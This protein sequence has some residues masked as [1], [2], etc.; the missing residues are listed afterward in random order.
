MS[1]TWAYPWNAPRAAIA[2]P[3]PTHAEL[4]R[5][6]LRII[7]TLKAHHA[8]ALQPESVRVPVNRTLDS[9]EKA[10]GA[11]RAEAWL[12]H[13]VARALPRLN[14]VTQRYQLSEIEPRVSRAVFKGHFDTHAQQALA[15]HL[16]SLFHRYNRLPDL[17]NKAIDRLAGDIANFIRGELAD[18]D[19]ADETELKTLHRW[20]LRAGTIALQFNVTPPHWQRV[21][22]KV[23]RAE[24]IAPAVMR[25][26]SE[27]WWR[28]RLRRV[29]SQWREHLQIALGNVSKKKQPYA[30][31][32]CISA[33]REQRRRNREFLKGMELED[34]EGNRI[35]LIDKFDGSVANPAIRRCE[36]MTRI[37]GFETICQ[38]L[39]YVGEFYTLT[40][41]AA[42]HAT[43]RAGYR[44]HKW[45]GASPAQT[46]A[47][48]T[49]LWAR[50]RARLHR[51]GLRIFG[52]RV[53]EP[54]HDGTP[55][56]HMLLFMQPADVAAVREILRELACQQ[57]NQELA[58]EKAKKARFHAEA[59]DPEKGSATGYVAK[60]IAKNIDGYA[61]EGESDNE[62]GAPLQETACAV[63]AWAA[64]W[65]IRQFQFIGGA[66]VTVYRELRRLR[67]GETARGL[68]VEFA[69]VHDAA[70]AGDW[71]G[72][73]NAQG[74]PFVRRDDLQV[75]TLYEPESGFNQYGE[76]MLTIRGVYDTSVGSGSPVLTRLKKWK[77]VPKRAGVDLQ[78]APAPSWSSVNNCTAAEN[79][80]V[81]ELLYAEY[82]MCRAAPGGQ[83]LPDET[84]RREDFFQSQALTAERENHKQL[85]YESGDIFLAD[86][87]YSRVDFP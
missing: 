8:L 85:L 27:Q 61:L 22:K 78:G 10:H 5:R 80:R 38:A 23:A 2:S 71:A 40:A 48:F 66:P 1:I 63:S 26:F 79:G 55:H 57:D 87:E 72:Y 17:A 7:N 39:G 18:I 59:I 30:S 3:Y 64:R 34:E 65:H 54:H 16:V 12:R 4:H 81:A 45:N 33:W 52:I 6:N 69:E 50:I 11:A 51:N 77:I 83:F 36:L 49:A 24:D 21:L 70:D 76:S 20:Y 56:W 29:A 9:L 46:Q 25:L 14:R 73:V 31:R 28:G 43:T 19:T 62:S 58:S 75:R 74:G 84:A 60:Y 86:N 82:L 68:S 44:N 32:D 41:P 15:S 47:Y 53:A 67:D 35:S 42:W 13:F 37:R